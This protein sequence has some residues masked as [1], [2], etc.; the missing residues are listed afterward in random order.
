MQKVIGLSNLFKGNKTTT[1]GVK[2]PSLSAPKV[3]TGMG[4]VKPNLLT[5]S[6]SLL[7]K[8]KP[9]QVVSGVKG[10][11]IGLVADYAINSIA[12]TLITK[13]LENA[14]NKRR[15]NSVNKKFLEL[16]SEGV[17]EYYEKELPRRIV[18]KV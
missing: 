8:V 7:S 6:K 9:G 12:D 13:P 2:P 16:G 4:G 1:S 14:T 15:E 10:L 5:K 18:K 17:V 3:T 11:G